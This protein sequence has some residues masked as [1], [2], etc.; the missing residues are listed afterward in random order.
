LKLNKVLFTALLAAGSLQATIIQSGSGV[1][2]SSGLI[3]QNFS[4]AASGTTSE[5]GSLNGVTFS[6][7]TLSSTTSTGLYYD[8]NGKGLC[9]M[10]A[11][12]NGGLPNATLVPLTNCVGDYALGQVVNQA[13]AQSSL[14]GQAPNITIGFAVPVYDASFVFALPGAAGPSVFTVT[15]KKGNNVVDSVTT[16]FTGNL[17]NPNAQYLNIMNEGA[18]DTI[19]ITQVAGIYNAN[20]NTFNAV[21]GNINA[22]T[23][24]PEP[25]TIGLFGLGFAGLA[26]FA[27]RRKA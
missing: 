22:T 15:L 5:Q 3:S 12:G 10:G 16:G 26:Y 8:P 4:S 7:V 20:G 24:A 2:F 19:S 27:R 21:I 13:H 17:L 1:S 6:G 23:T 25:G 9:S 18:F 11:Q 14:V